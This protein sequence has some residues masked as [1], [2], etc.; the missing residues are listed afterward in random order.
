[1]ATINLNPDN[2]VYQD[3]NDGEIMIFAKDDLP[4]MKQFELSAHYDTYARIKQHMK[5]SVLMEGDD[6]N[7]QYKVYES[8]TFWA[9]DG[10]STT[11][12]I[13]GAKLGL[14]KQ[15]DQTEIELL[16][17]LIE[18]IE[19][20]DKNYVPKPPEPISI[21]LI[22]PDGMAQ[23]IT[24]Y[25]MRLPTE[26][27]KNGRVYSPE[28]LKEAVQSYKQTVECETSLGG[29]VF[30]EMMVDRPSFSAREHPNLEKKE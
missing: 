8:L 14:N 7:E 16:L 15:Y 1:M 11:I 3:S 21:N 27:N 9:P 24:A 22:T 28:A 25:P 19:E 26:P 10:E 23:K 17:K 20:E 18:A 30:S 5:T 29:A 6:Y 12:P 4:E 13:G 2:Y